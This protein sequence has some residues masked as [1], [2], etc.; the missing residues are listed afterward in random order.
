[1]LFFATIFVI[2][3]YL[4]NVLLI[5]KQARRTRRMRDV[6]H[7]CFKFKFKFNFIDLPEAL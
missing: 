6:R 2:K 5:E 3:A 1:M 7:E 4:P